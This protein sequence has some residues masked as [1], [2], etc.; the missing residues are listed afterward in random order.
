MTQD[1]N[2][3]GLLK[4]RWMANIDFTAH[5]MVKGHCE[6]LQSWVCFSQCTATSMGNLDACCLTYEITWT[7]NGD[8]VCINIFLRLFKTFAVNQTL[9]LFTVVGGKAKEHEISQSS[10]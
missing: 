10:V 9:F 5:Q 1:K 2:H 3:K 4:E 8:Y 6:E 7:W